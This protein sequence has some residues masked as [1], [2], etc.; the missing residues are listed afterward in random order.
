M[1]QSCKRGIYNTSQFIRI[2]NY[3]YMKFNVFLPILVASGLLL[4]C[5]CVVGVI[6]VIMYGGLWVVVT[7]TEWTTALRNKHKVLNYII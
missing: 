7:S 4:T 1:M 2:G 5:S 6:L 3:L